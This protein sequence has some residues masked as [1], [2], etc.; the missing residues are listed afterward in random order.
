NF[1][2][3]RAHVAG[4]PRF[5][6]FLGQVRKTFFEAFDHQNYTFGSLI[7]KLNLPRN[8][9]RMPLLSATF[10]LA[11]SRGELNLAGLKT[12]LVPNP[13]CFA[14]FDITCDVIERDGELDAIFTPSLRKLR[15]TRGSA[16][17]SCRSCPL[18]SAI[19]SWSNGT[20]L[21]CGMLAPKGCNR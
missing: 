5:T 4:N 19:K 3:L 17:A 10:N 8:S 15:R 6:D 18:P 11:R 21:G 2:P 20:S 12:K 9:S 13:K 7:Q 16:L 1:L 14:N